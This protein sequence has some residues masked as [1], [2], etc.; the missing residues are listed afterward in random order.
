LR[1]LYLTK[2]K[3]WRGWLLKNHHRE[4][5][6]WLVYYKAGTGKP[7]ISY[8]DAVLE[9]LCFGWID[10]TVK[11]LDSRR[12]AQRFSPRKSTSALSQMNKERVRKLIQD[13]KMTKAGLR[14][15]AHVYD[16]K[17]DKISK[18]SIPPAILEAI[19]ANKQ[20]W[21]NFRKLPQAYK[22]IRI[23]YVQSRLRHGKEMYDKALQN[24]I[25]MTAKNK[26]IGFVKEWR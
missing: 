20:A 10:S 26:R 24:F 4:P 23:A 3:D 14:A 13:G 22:R 9:A 25:R 19:K 11:N 12:F 15:I 18:F 16:P 8:D 5:E 21:I 17:K 7:R 1:P 2:R 6:T